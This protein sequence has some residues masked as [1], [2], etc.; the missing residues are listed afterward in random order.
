MT[1]IPSIPIQTP[2]ITQTGGVFRFELVWERF[3]KALADVLMEATRVGQT[4][5]GLRFVRCGAQI[6]VAYHDT[7]RASVRLPFPP[8]LE[9]A[10]D[11]FDGST[12]SK[13]IPTENPDGTFS[14]AVP[15]LAM[16]RVSGTYIVDM[17]RS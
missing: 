11:V 8:A 7:G 17:G 4:D 2:P 13:A 16:S 5:E 1:P 14:V 9:A 15:I 6:F 12:W 10:L 3:I